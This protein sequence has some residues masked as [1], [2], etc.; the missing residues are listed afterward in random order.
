MGGSAVGM[1]GIAT[2][3]GYRER[4]ILK[5]SFGLVGLLTASCQFFAVVLTLL[6]SGKA[7]WPFP[8]DRLS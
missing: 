8:L 2:F 4:R 1:A 3:F 5:A 7:T 6:A